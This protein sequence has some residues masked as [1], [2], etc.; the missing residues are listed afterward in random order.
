MVDDAQGDV[1]FIAEDRFNEAGGQGRVAWGFSFVVESHVMAVVLDDL[2]QHGACLGKETV[3]NP[4]GRV[5]SASALP[6]VERFR[7]VVKDAL[8]QVV[9]CVA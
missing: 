7:P 6:P 5:R 3:R 9:D 8:L 1:G 4:F 2:V